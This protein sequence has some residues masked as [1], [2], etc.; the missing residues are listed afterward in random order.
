MDFSLSPLQDLST[1]IPRCGRGKRAQPAASMRKVLAVHLQEPPFSSTEEGGSPREPMPMMAPALSLQT[2]MKGE[3]PCQT[4]VH[5]LFSYLKEKEEEEEEETAEL[6]GFSPPPATSSQLIVKQSCHSEVH[7][8]LSYLKKEEEEEEEVAEIVSLSPPHILPAPA[9]PPPPPAYLSPAPLART[10]H[11]AGLEMLHFFNP[12]AHV[13]A[14]SSQPKRGRDRDSA[15]ACGLA[16]AIPPP[17]HKKT[18]SAVWD[19]FTLDPREPCV[20][21]CSTCQKRVRRGKDGGTR[22]G[23]TALHKHLKVHHGL[24]LPGVAVVPPSPLA[25]L[26]ERLHG[27]SMVIPDPSPTFQFPRQERNQPYYPPTHPTALQLASDTAWMLAVDMQPF[28]YVESEGFRRLMATAQPRWKVP[29]RV[30]FSSKAMPE[31]SRVVSRAVRQAVVCSMGRTVHI[32]IDTWASG[33]TTS[34]LSVTGCWVAELA[35]ALSRQHATLSVCTFEGPCLPEDICHK[36]REVLQDWLYDLKIGGVVSDNGAKVAGAVQELHLKHVPC[37]ARC[38]QRVVK[39]FLAADAQV[40]RLLKTSRSICRYCSHSAAARRRLLEAQANLG[41]RQPTWQEAQAKSRSTLRMLE[42]LYRQR[43]A[44][45]VM[46][47]EASSEAS[48]LHLTPADWKLV[49]CLVE[50]LKPFEDAATLVTRP[51]ATLCQALPLL[52]FLEEQLRALRTRYHQENHNTAAHL[53]TQALDCLEN[54]IQ[55]RGMKTSM[56]CRVAA[57]L[58]PRFRDITTM[59]LG[60]ADVSDAALL[61]EHIIDLAARSYVPPGPDA[62]FTPVGCLSPQPSSSSTSLPG[63]AAWQFTLKRWRAITKSDPA[64]GLA[65]EGG[66]AAALWEVEEYL[67]DNVDHVGENADPMLYWQGKIGIWPALFKVAVFHFGCPPTSVFSEDL[68]STAGSLAVGDHP[69][70]LSPAN[71]K[72]FTFIRKNR[73]LIPQDWRLS[74]GDLSSSQGAMGPREDLDMEEEEDL[75][76]MDKEEEEEEEK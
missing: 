71:V 68:S 51:D 34:Y 10:V 43:Q 25:P 66:A 2:A 26:K 5:D 49:K 58:D 53:T 59:K 37:L 45:G 33:P 29:G 61:R 42:C 23:T 14:P 17:V 20:A 13:S 74:L 76:I 38:L 56:I 31:L 12:L 24:H 8:M 36:L 54:D 69:R 28:S 3:E 67:H 7:E 9:T 63:S 57:F 44:V 39:A 55:L 64:M 52:W 30:F 15:L 32:A 40:A 75:L 47:S 50:I 19:Y 35:G 18:T 48:H 1:M 72:M 62:K 4:T 22:P 21:I 70:N 16:D 65:T 27:H 46:L 6:G 41:L 60:G 73:H 11:P